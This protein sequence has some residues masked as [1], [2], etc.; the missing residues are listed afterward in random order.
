MTIK[1]Y[2][3]SLL[4]QILGK[5]KIMIRPNRKDLL[6]YEVITRLMQRVFFDQ[7]TVSDFAAIEEL[8]DAFGKPR[9]LVIRFLHKNG[10]FSYDDYIAELKKPKT[11]ETIEWLSVITVEIHSYLEAMSRYFIKDQLPQPEI[12]ELK[13]PENV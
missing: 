8:L 2:I 6:N 13:N 12:W 5:R 3:G 7:V 1:T 11:D 4:P 9:D 10:I